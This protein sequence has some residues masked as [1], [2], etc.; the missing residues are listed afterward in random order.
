MTPL[1]IVNGKLQWKN[2][3]RGVRRKPGEMNKTEQAYSIVLEARKRAGEIEQWWFE[4]ITLK[5]GPDVRYTADFMVLEN[6]GT[7][8]LIDVKGATKTRHTLKSTG[9]RRRIPRIEDDAK[10]KIAVAAAQFPF[11]FVMV[12]PAEGG[13]W[14]SRDV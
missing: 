14:E 7:L 12:W 10:V 8:S 3:A 4:G 11:R 13:G 2:K 9:E 5:L 6:D 1:S